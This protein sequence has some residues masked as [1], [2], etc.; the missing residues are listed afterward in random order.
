VSP[1]PSSRHSDPYTYNEDNSM[2]ATETAEV[3]AALNDLENEIDDTEDALTQW[4][5]SG[6]SATTGSFSASSPSY[7]SSTVATGQEGAY[8]TT[9]TNVDRDW[10]ILSTIS[11]RTENPSRPTSHSFSPGGVARP[12]NPTPDALRRS[13]HLVS[14]SAASPH[15]RSSTDPG[16]VAPPPGRRAGDLIAFFEDR[17]ASSDIS[18]TH[19]R[20]VSAPSGPRS[21]SPYISGSRSTPNLESTTGYGYASTTGYGYSS[22]PSSPS[23]SSTS[24]GSGPASMSSLRS[25]P[26]RGTTTFSD[27]TGTTSRVR[28]PLTTSETSYLSPSTYTNTFTNTFTNTNTSTVTDTNTGSLTPTGSLRRPQTSPRSPLT[29]VRNIVAAWKERTPT[30]VK[31]GG[32]SGPGSATSGDAT[33]PPQASRGEGLFRRRAE[34]GTTRLRDAGTDGRRISVDRTRERDRVGNGESSSG[35]PSTPMSGSTS[36][37]PPPFDAAELG[38]YARESREVSFLFWNSTSLLLPLLC[39]MHFKRD[40]IFSLL[41]LAFAHWST[42]VPQCSRSAAL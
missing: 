7:S 4:S 20:T 26:T 5:R 6:R 38:A 42:L 39:E 19:S 29:S 3:E 21:P 28:S 2:D 13:A 33:S 22:R 18:G 32:R 41:S 12:M 17:T 24:S 8:P 35:R 31:S 37:V 9:A 30:L 16:A 1:S 36:G 34:R 25:P 40:L 14:S 23:K 10:R 15:S 11:E 27:V